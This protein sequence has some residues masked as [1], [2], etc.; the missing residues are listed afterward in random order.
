MAVAPKG[1]KFTKYNGHPLVAFGDSA[2]PPQFGKGKA[3]AIV[4]LSDAGVEITK[5]REVATLFGVRVKDV[6]PELLVAG[7]R[8]LVDHINA[9]AE[10]A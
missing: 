1:T 9:T 2:K 10:A 8:A 6:E 3:E 4:M 7:A 5:I